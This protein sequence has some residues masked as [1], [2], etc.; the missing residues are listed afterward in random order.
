MV[1]SESSG[2]ADARIDALEKD[3]AAFK[4]AA[5]M[6]INIRRLIMVAAIVLVSVICWQ[7]YSFA[8][9][10]TSDEYQKKL[11]DVATERLKENEENY[12]KQVKTLVNESAP[13]LKDAFY[14][15][16]KT[17][18]PKYTA[19]FAAE[20]DAFAKSIEGKMREQI[21]VHYR[22][23]LEKYQD[24]LVKEFPELDSP[25]LKQKAMDA[26]GSAF[27]QLVETYYVDALAEGIEEIYSHWDDF[28]TADDS[29]EWASPPEDV[30]IGL[31]ME[32]VSKKMA[33]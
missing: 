2:N 25:E 26:V 11:I 9:E 23:L 14:N 32:L 21:N 30:L 19:A 13:V 3:Y 18:M 10:L 7:F 16:T 27:E 29:E 1:E 22:S 5:A 15:Q 6:S 33:N 31:L 8:K 4:S 28:P 17:D 12:L 24:L 20:R